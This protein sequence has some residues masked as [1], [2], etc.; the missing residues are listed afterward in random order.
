MDTADSVGLVRCQYCGQYTP[1]GMVRYNDY[2]IQN[3]PHE[4]CIDVTRMDR[5]PRSEWV[6]SSHCPKEENATL[7]P[8]ATEAQSGTT[9]ESTTTEEQ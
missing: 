2:P 6:C 9:E 3:R 5:V 7:E 4:T 8:Q 1:D